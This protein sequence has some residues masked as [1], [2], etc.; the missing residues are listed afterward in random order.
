MKTGTPNAKYP[1]IFTPGAIGRLWVKN[2]IVRAPMYT[3]F[4]G[5]DGCVTKRTINH[6]REFARGGAGLIVVGE[7]DIDDKASRSAPCSLCISSAEHQPGLGWLA[8]TIQENGAKACLQLFHKGKQTFM[9]REIPLKAPSR[10]PWEDIYEMFGVPVPEELSIEEIEEIIEAF[11]NGA[12]RAKEAGF[13]MVDILGNSG[14]L[15]TNFLSPRDNK[16]SDWYGGSLENRMRF[17]LQVVRNIRRKVGGDYPLSVRLNGVDYVEGGTTVAETKEVCIALERAGVN[18]IHI[19]GGTHQVPDM[20]TVTMY[21]PLAN[22]LEAAKEIKAVVHIP[23]IINGAITSPELAEKILAEGSADFV[24]LA[25]PLLADPYFPLKAKEGRPEDIRPCIRCMEGCGAERGGMR[26]IHCTVNATVGREEDLRITQTTKAK[27]IA[28][29][30]GG[31][32]GMEAA[33]VAALSGHKVTLYEK[34]KLGG[35]LI[36]ASLPEFKADLRGLIDNLS[37]QVKKA[38]VNIVESEATLQTI[39]AGNF[40]VAIVATGASPCVLEVAGGDKPLVLDPFDVLRG[41]KTGKDIVV[42]GGGAIGCDVALFLAEQGKK[43]TI[44]TR[45]DDIAHG[46][47]LVMKIA[48]FK[49]YFRPGVGM[50]TGMHLVEIVD[51]GVV[52]ADRFGRTTEFKADNVVL[53]TGLEPL[54]GLYEEL[55]QVPGLEV[56]AVGNC[57]EP[58]TIFDAIHEGYK[59]AQHIR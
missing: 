43:V 25:R 42:V 40:D 31:P 13:D 1:K 23:V 7:V 14:Y 3:G 58:R 53:A 21:G 52:L 54:N 22:N 39:K 57:V 29:V 18:V 10:V 56:Y 24:G 5:K 45:Q 17:L 8:E 30:G 59:A 20:E 35:M 19:T 16:R 27:D 12:F 9:G 55:A 32:A 47:T 51:N 48:F 6:Y 38:G 2:R 26:G 50:L 46:L 4:A 44:T 33:R 41:A 11:G 36:E 49:R 34:R 15:I 28:V 37:T